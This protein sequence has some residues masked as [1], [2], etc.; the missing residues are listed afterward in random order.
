MDPNA[1]LIRLLTAIA[2]RD[3]WT[4]EEACDDLSAWVKR[5]GVLPTLPPE[6]AD[7]V[8]VKA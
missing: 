7:A 2:E 1:T 8:A 5:G 4:I 6:V 3:A